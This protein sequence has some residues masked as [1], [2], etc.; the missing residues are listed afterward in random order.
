[1][2]CLQEERAIF[3]PQNTII[4]YTI[5]LPTTGLQRQPS[6]MPLVRA[7]FYSLQ[8]K[9]QISPQLLQIEATFTHRISSKISLVLTP[10]LKNI[11]KDTILLLIK[12]IS[13]R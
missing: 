7:K 5:I 11:K 3:P 10:F 6:Q 9:W 8:C 2:I 4:K 12:N 13:S 1:M